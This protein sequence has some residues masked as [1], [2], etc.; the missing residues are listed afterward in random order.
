MSVSDCFSPLGINKFLVTSLLVLGVEYTPFL[1][2][3]FL[4]LI[5]DKIS[6]P[7]DLD[8]GS[9]CNNYNNNN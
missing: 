7:L 5:Y 2:D 9:G 4:D 6:S 8:F 3:K 1:N